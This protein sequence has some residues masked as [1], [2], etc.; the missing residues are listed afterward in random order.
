MTSCIAIDDDPLF[1]KTLEMYFHE[2]SGAELIGTFTNPV[3]GIMEVVKKKPQVLLLDIEMP[4]LDGFET[5]STLDSR[6]KIIVISGHINESI[7]PKTGID[8]YLS[9]TELTS[10]QLLQRA[11]E[12]VLR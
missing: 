8:R 4:Y 10:P 5:L 12:D 3:E 7:L 1:L 6:P 2:I 9:K 11:I